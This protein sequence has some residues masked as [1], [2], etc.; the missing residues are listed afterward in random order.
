MN[1]VET[2]HQEQDKSK[3]YYKSHQLLKN[4]THAHSFVAQ[5]LGKKF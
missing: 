3:I 2:Y 4:T 5:V 1:S